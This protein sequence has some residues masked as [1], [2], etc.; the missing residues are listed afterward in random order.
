MFFENSNMFSHKGINGWKTIPYLSQNN[1]L[2]GYWIVILTCFY[3]SITN[4]NFLSTK[5]CLSAPLWDDVVSHS[6]TYNSYFAHPENLC[7]CAIMSK[8]SSQ[9]V[10]EQAKEKILEFRKVKVSKRVNSAA[11]GFHQFVTKS[12]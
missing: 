3:H 1:T 2:M 4:P 9:E 10:K 11:R 8:F 7:F 6:F 12:P 5:N